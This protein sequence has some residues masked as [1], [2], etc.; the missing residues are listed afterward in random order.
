MSRLRLLPSTSRRPHRTA[1]VPADERPLPVRALVALAGAIFVSMT[2]EFLP[3]GLLPAISRDLDVS[4]AASGQLVS[5][6]AATVIVFTAP[7][8][9]LTR[10]VDRRRLLAIALGVIALSSLAT[11]LAPGYGWLLAARVLG[12]VA[13][14]AFWSVAA[15]YTAHLVPTAQLARATVIVSGGGSL[16]GILGVPIGNA[17]G[18]LVG[19]RWA[20]V[21]LAAA[22][23]AA[24][25]VLI[26]AVPRIAPAADPAPRRHRDATL[27]LILGMCAL[28]V[29]T[30]LSQTAF[31]TYLTPWLEAEA[32]FPAAAIP[33]YLF[34]T[35]LAGAVGLAVS[36]AAGD[37]Y[38]RATLLGGLAVVLVSLILFALAVDAPTIALIAAGLVW[39]AGFGAVSPLLQARMMRIASER[40]RGTAAALQTVAFNVGIGGG[41]VI[42][43]GIIAAWGLGSLPVFAIA[44]TAVS[45]TAIAMTMRRPLR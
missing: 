32:G 11:A 27:P 16:A 29:L 38:P 6:F 13:H 37:R 31:G 45:L 19:W 15:A 34:A 23:V 3:G 43:G 8:A 28:I 40:A 12:G 9:A 5:V 26:R 14:G 35:G 17:L 41:A 2:V 30:V 33:A 24:L 7:V 1:H 21:A 39:S 36:G 4:V 25:A 10:R 22:G 18:Q 44:A 20:F 42:G